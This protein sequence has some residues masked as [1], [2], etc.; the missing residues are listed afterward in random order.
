VRPG[1]TWASLLALAAGVALTGGPVRGQDLDGRPLGR[2]KLSYYHLAEERESGEVPVFGSDCSRV[3]ARTG[4]DFHDRLSL[5]GTGLLADGRLLNFEQR[6]TC[7]VAG[8][9]GA[10]S[11]YRVL[12][13][14]QF[15]WGRGAYWN[16]QFFW[17]QP[18]RTVAVDPA[19]IPI[20]SVVYV[21]ELAGR[22]LPD[23]TLSNGCLRAEDTGRAIRGRHL[24]WFIGQA[25]SAQWL[26]MHPPPPE[27][28]AFAESRRCTR[29]FP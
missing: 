5:E 27:V 13:R 11:C 15:P 17:L 9:Q 12:S 26:R 7:A 16:G 2:F 10:R 14:E 3:I 24:D 18:F 19:L 6:C 1:L 28:S 29:A 20:G 22:A 8:Y 25:R 23:G 21:P 4:R